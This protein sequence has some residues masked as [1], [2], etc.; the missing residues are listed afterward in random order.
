M[1]K[2]TQGEILVIRRRRA[3]I[4]QTEAATRW[5]VGR[6][7]YS[8]WE[9]DEVKGPTVDLVTPLELH[10]RCFIKRRRA[11]KSRAEIARAV[12]VSEF[13]VTEMERG[14]RPCDR[15]VRYWK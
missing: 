15:L 3:D 10:E 5:S 1:F 6:K 13:W 7:L 11:G 8:K 14:R 9:L 12:G 2:L 4:S